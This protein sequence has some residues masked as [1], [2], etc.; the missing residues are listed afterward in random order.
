MVPATAWISSTMTVRT[1]D[2]IAR[3]LSDDSSTYSDSGVVTR[4]CGAR[5]RIALR[6]GVVVSPVRTAARMPCG[7]SPMA[8]SWRPMPS[9]GACRFR[10]M[11]F[12]SAFSGDTYSTWVSSGSGASLLS[13]TSASMAARKAVSVLP[14]PVGAATRVGRPA[15]ICGQA[16]N[17]ASVAAGK[18]APNQAATAG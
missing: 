18:V 16:R 1:D 8:A 6:S 4:M 12:D 7:G 15:W 9:S 11:S 3:P 13:R 10:R 14:E 5:R 2:S 17:C